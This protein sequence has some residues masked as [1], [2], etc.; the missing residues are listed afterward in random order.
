LAQDVACG[1]RGADSQS[2]G[3]DALGEDAVR[4]DVAGQDPGENG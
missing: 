2:G 3:E 4:A 1:D